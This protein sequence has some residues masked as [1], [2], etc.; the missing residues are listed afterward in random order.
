MELHLF[1]TLNALKVLIALEEMAQPCD[2]VLVDIMNGGQDD[3]AFRAINPNGRIPA[4]VD[5]AVQVFESAAILQYLGRKSGRF[6]P[7]DEAV[8]ARIDS[9]LFWQMAGLGPASGNL[10][11]F[12]RAAQKPGRDPAETGLA[13]HRFRKETA[14][15]FDVLEGALA[16]RDYLCGDYS[17]ADM[18][19]WTWI[20]KYPAGGGGLAGRPALAAWHSRIGA[21]LAVARAIATAERLTQEFK[22]RTPS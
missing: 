16:G 5:A 12:E 1:P 4:L 19:C 10:N 11:W 22:E 8:R 17:I 15:L 20:D 21:R 13:L 7:A 2:L 9:W 3:P 6:Y 18:C 14:R